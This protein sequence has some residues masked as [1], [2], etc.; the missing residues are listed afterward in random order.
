ML[1]GYFQQDFAA[2]Y[3]SPEEAAR[4]FVRGAKP[5]QLDKAARQL[6]RF[7]EHGQSLA[8]SEWRAAF[9]ALG[10]AWQPASLDAIGGIASLLE[11]SVPPRYSI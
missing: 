3:G 7:H 2:T 8:E 9:S 10:G 1:D 4:A 5:K 11:E 6:K